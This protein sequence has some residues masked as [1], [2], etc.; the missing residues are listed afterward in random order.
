[1][2]DWNR[3]PAG[4]LAAFPCKLKTFRKRIREAVTNKEA[5]SGDRMETSEV[6]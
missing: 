5:L 1:M 4:V 2:K 3:L 6:M